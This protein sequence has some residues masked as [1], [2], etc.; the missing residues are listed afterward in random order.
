MAQAAVSEVLL[1]PAALRGTSPIPGTPVLEQ[2]GVRVRL[3]PVELGRLFSP[4]GL[5]LVGTGAASASATSLSFFGSFVQQNNDLLRIIDQ[6]PALL[7]RVTSAGFEDRSDL[8][9]LLAEGVRASL[10][11]NT[12]L[13]ERFLS[14]NPELTSIL[15]LNLGGLRDRVA[16]D[17]ALASA[18]TEGQT[19]QATLTRRL[20]EAAAAGTQGRGGLDTEFFTARPVAAAYLLNDPKQ[21]AA[22]G[23]DTT[24]TRAADFLKRVSL[25]TS[26]LESTVAG[27]ARTFLNNVTGYPDAY[28]TADSSF[29]ALIAGAPRLSDHQGFTT[30]LR[31]HPEL[32][33]NGVDAGS[34]LRSYEVELAS[35][36]ITA[37]DAQASQVLDRSFLSRNIGLAVAINEFPEVRQALLTDLPRLTALDAQARS[38]ASALQNEDAL[39]AAFSKT[40]RTGTFSFFF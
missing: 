29:T 22:I 36:R 17:P 15:A 31:T 16:E 40:A 13:T 2:D 30:F 5:A 21:L 19:L 34:L 23:A 1:A 32:T 9:S 20:A 8:L 11:A 27:Q 10:P 28:L 14:E 38:S 24:N 35:S 26:T 25:D 7:A 4:D 39:F 12:P 18:L 37:S 33:L 3:A 6:D